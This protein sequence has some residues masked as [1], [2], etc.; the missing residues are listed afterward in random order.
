MFDIFNKKKAAIAANKQIELDAS[1]AVISA[2]QSSMA[3]I[4][5]SPSGE[6]ITA[7]PN[8]LSAVGYS[9]QEVA[10][11]HHSMFCESSLTRSAEYKAFWQQ[12]TSGQFVS[13]E[14]KRIHKDGHDLWLEASYNPVYDQNGQVVKVV[15]LAS[16]VTEKLTKGG[17]PQHCC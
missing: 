13:G 2:L 11:K 3:I 4:E 7:N 12:L 5:F 14:F 10:G 6:I 15:K 8:F 9:L 16:D 17:T 1:N